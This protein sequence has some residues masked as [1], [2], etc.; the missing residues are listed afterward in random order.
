MAVLIVMAY[1]VPRTIL[2]FIDQDE[3][4][5]ELGMKAKEFWL[6]KFTKAR[7]V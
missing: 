5:R 7:W 3:R 1:V 4:Q 6:S 2:W